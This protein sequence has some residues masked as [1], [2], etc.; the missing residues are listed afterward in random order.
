MC[1]ANCH[2]HCQLLCLIPA[3]YCHYTQLPIFR[4]YDKYL[5]NFFYWIYQASRRNA[6]T[7]NSYKPC[8]LEIARFLFCSSA[9]FCHFWYVT[10]FFRLANFVISFKFSI[11]QLQI[12]T[13]T[14]AHY[15]HNNFGYIYLS[16]HNKY[17]VVNTVSLWIIF[18]FLSA[19]AH[20]H[21]YLSALMNT[22]IWVCF[23]YCCRCCVK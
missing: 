1:G 11:M 22:L 8:C 7:M 18:S 4:H 21:F 20:F 10:L 9:S 17:I 15:I 12:N 19:F 2:W 6:N 5:Y 3:V 23:C 13:Q 14:E 16:S